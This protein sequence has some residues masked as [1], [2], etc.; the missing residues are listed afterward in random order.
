MQLFHDAALSH[1]GWL[2]LV[3]LAV[4]AGIAALGLGRMK[5]GCA[6]ALGACALGLLS[7]Q[8]FEP[9][10]NAVNQGATGRDTIR[11]VLSFGALSWLGGILAEGGAAARLSGAFAGTAPGVRAV[12]EPLAAGFLPPS[13]PPPRAGGA[14]RAPEEGWFSGI[15][16]LAFPVGTT[17]VLAAAAGGLSLLEAARTLAPLALALLAVGVLCFAPRE[18]L[19]LSWP[20]MGTVALVLFPAVLAVALALLLPQREIPEIRAADFLH[21][22]AEGLA[23]L[24]TPLTAGALLGGLVAASGLGLGPAVLMKLLKRAF[25]ADLLALAAGARI[26]QQV[27]T[28]PGPSDQTP[29]GATMEALSRLGPAA[30]LMILVIPAAIAFLASDAAIAIACAIPFLLVAGGGPAFT[31]ICAGA[32]LG[33]ALSPRNSRRALALPVSLGALAAAVLCR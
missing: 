14:I 23:G 26:L 29:A 10:F 31:L 3:V 33:A 8:R 16:A 19:S 24:A 13:S 9:W 12:L 21:R 25:S 27:A 18:K 1:P 11:L 5:A 7:A 4:V 28:V 32:W 15:P 6:L 22:T 17:L 20:D 30:P 2:P